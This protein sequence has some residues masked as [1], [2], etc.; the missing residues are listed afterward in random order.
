[1]FQNQLPVITP[2]FYK[3]EEINKSLFSW[4]Y[5]KKGIRCGSEFESPV[6]Y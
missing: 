6:A 5:R 2:E 3:I 1:M 4:K